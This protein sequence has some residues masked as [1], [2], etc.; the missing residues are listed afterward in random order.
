[1]FIDQHIIIAYRHMQFVGVL[2][3]LPGEAL[4]LK[5]LLEYFSSVEPTFFVAERVPNI[6]QEITPENFK[7]LLSE[8][9]QR[10][11]LEGPVSLDD[12]SLLYIPKTLH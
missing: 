12:P 5:E 3:T 4:S 2:V 11:S 10:Y 8:K 9:I 1:M 6:N 7:E